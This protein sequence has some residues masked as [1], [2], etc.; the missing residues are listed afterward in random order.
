MSIPFLTNKNKKERKRKAR[1]NAS[2]YGG[3]SGRGHKGQKSRSGYSRMAGFEGGQTPLYRRLP[4]SNGFK[5][6]FKTE[7]DIINLSTLETSF[8]DGAKV[9]KDI[10]S[11]L[12]LVSG[13][14]PVKLLG[15]GELSKSLSIVV[16]AASK[17]SVTIVEKLKGTITFT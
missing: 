8:D 6:Q 15:N 17:S 11:E 5:N 3:E 16:D 1:G 7:F 14:R 12:N 2:G 10:L 4:K 9:D 13:K